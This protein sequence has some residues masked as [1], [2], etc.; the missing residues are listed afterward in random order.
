M[1]NTENKIKA[2]IANGKKYQS[3]LPTP[4]KYTFLMRSPPCFNTLEC[5][6]LFFV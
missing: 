6:Y 4:L 1:V 3:I 2:E 5:R